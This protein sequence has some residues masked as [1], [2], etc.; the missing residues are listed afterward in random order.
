[1]M[2]KVREV[3]KMEK[4]QAA[5]IACGRLFTPF[6]LRRLVEIDDE[7]RNLKAELAGT[8][9][10][11]ADFLEQQRDVIRRHI[12]EWFIKREHKKE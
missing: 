11:N 5:C 4:K 6:S 7:L 1:M 8:F 9:V 10:I 3:V 2:D 12:G